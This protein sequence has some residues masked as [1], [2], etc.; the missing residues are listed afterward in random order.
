MVRSAPHDDVVLTL[1]DGVLTLEQTPID[2]TPP[3][4]ELDAAARLLL[5]WGRREP[6]APIDLNAGGDEMITTLLGW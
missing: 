4:V 2:N 1:S 5:L 3:S 6:S